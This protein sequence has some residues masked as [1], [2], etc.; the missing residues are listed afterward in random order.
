MKLIP[1][2]GSPAFLSPKNSNQLIMGS[3]DC[4][5]FNPDIERGK[6][7]SPQSFRGFMSKKLFSSTVFVLTIFITSS[8][9]LGVQ[10][11][12]PS[13]LQQNSLSPLHAIFRIQRHSP[14]LS[15]FQRSNLLRVPVSFLFPSSQILE[16]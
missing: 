14:S 15:S 1:I 5:L 13:S 11:F 12:F 4:L 6:T 9:S 7:M 10:L 2:F 8:F 3:I 16:I